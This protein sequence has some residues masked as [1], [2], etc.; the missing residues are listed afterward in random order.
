MF[1]SPDIQSAK[2]RP[3]PHRRVPR[4]WFLA[5]AA[6]SLYLV[7]TIFNAHSLYRDEIEETQAAMLAMSHAIE[8]QIT[9][10][11]DNLERNAVL[12]ERDIDEHWSTPRLMPVPNHAEEFSAFVDRIVLLSATGRVLEDVQSGQ[13]ATQRPL[14]AQMIERLI[15]HTDQP[16]EIHL[17]TLTD[18]A[19]QT[20]LWLMHHINGPEGSLRNLLALS[21][22]LEPLR[23]ELLE[24]TRQFSDVIAVFHSDA[25][26]LLRAP[27]LLKV[28]GNSFADYPLFSRELKESRAGF[29]L[30]EAQSDGKARYVGYT[31]SQDMPLVVA[32]ALDREHVTDHLWDYYLVM[33]LN[34]AI[35]AIALGGICTVAHRALAESDARLVE[36]DRTLDQLDMARN[37]LTTIVDALPANIVV[38][39]Q[40]GTVLM[41]NDNWQQFAIANGYSGADRG[42]GRNYL[43]VCDRATGP[44]SD[45]A[46]TAAEGIRAVLDGES[47]FF[48]L[49]YPC[50]SPEEQR[51][52][53]LIVTPIGLGDERGA[54]VTHVNITERQ[55]AEIALQAE[56]SRLRSLAASTPGVMFQA[57]CDGDA[58]LRLT[59]ISERCKD[60]FGIRPEPGMTMDAL[61]S[62]TVP[63]S[64]FPE[65]EAAFAQSRK[66]GS[67]DVVFRVQRQDGE[68][69]W[70][71]AVASTSTDADGVTRHCDGIF[72]DITVEK[73]SIER[74][75]YIAEHDEL[76]GLPNRY[77]FERQLQ[78]VIDRQKAGGEPG[79]VYKIGLDDFSEVNEAFG[80]KAGDLFLVAAADRLRG[81][82]RREHALSRIGGDRFA[83]I[84][85]YPGGDDRIEATAE[86]LAHAFSEPLKVEGQM[87]L[88][89]AS[90]GVTRITDDN[91]P[92][93]LDNASVALRQAKNTAKGGHA[94]FSHESE[95]ETQSR[96]I[97]RNGL[98]SAIENNEFVLNYQPRMALA[99]NR[100][101]GA[102]ALLRWEHPAFGLQSPTRFIP[103]AEQSGLIV[104]IGKWVLHEACRQA[105]IWHAAGHRDFRMAVNVSSIQLRRSNFVETVREALQDHNLPADGLT[106]EMTEAVAF[107]HSLRHTLDELHALG[108]GIAIDDFGTGFSSLSYL[109]EFPLDTLKID[110]SFVRLAGQG[111]GDKVIIDAI[112][113]LARGLHLTTVAEGVETA[114]HLH[115]LQRLGCDE[116]QGYFVAAPMDA[117]DMTWFLDEGYRVAVAKLTNTEMT[118][119][120]DGQS[121]T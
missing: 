17:V 59:L 70:L 66:T 100:V 116:I 79:V 71:H 102:E 1:R 72:L 95:I 29:F 115:M 44:G 89:S 111:K 96:M 55:R 26:L 120:E 37:R 31:T 48:E 57:T 83:V 33:I 11:F 9:R 3:L 52:F 75:E 28:A 58:P 110:Q 77:R 10:V 40:R 86:R 99:D 68:L 105:S 43:D 14:D 16:G 98:T 2:E 113:R 80:R 109:R 103:V 50:D 20:S 67:V 82:V 24:F 62:A 78:E 101:T 47:K 46:A 34:A 104:P 5:A 107:D 106:L 108:V 81:V 18:G 23:G 41:S 36:R 27:D 119:N 60:I 97:L 73:A 7:I 84:Q 19:G 42:V 56:R 4:F 25:T 22:T 53:R 39:D 35:F 21:I 69:R 32:V 12:I 30:A 63:A 93:V 121:S 38:L 88:V 13:R 64:D 65:V 51:W 74:L 49:G 114:E 54:V 91:A 45:D 15:H 6:F 61:L 112:V 8:A 118:G 76:T 85:T 87:A 92:G 117:D 94:F 90:V